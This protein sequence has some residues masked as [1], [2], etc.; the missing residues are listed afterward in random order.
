LGDPCKLFEL[1]TPG[2][3][4]NYMGE[5][6]SEPGVRHDP[7][8]HGTACYVDYDLRVMVCIQDFIARAH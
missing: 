2:H 3:H 4:G 7:L 6:D 8:F 1:F 5:S